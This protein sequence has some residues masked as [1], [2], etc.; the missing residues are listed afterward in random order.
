ME[1]LLSRSQE[2][3]M[4]GGVLFT[5]GVHMKLTA[6]EAEVFKRCKL[7]DLLLLDRKI[8]G[9]TV[10]RVTADK[11]VAG[12]SLG[13]ANFI[14]IAGCEQEIRERAEQ[15]HIALKRAMAFSGEEVLT[16]S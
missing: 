13:H 3:R 6:D 15:F 2:K 11:A 9:D 16:F 1:L 12:T 10:Y 14:A 4:L 5:L 8:E 7:G